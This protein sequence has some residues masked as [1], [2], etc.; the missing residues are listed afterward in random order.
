MPGWEV[1]Q[2]TLMIGEQNFYLAKVENEIGTLVHVLR[3][4]IEQCH[5]ILFTQYDHM[6]IKDSL[7]KGRVVFLPHGIASNDLR[8]KIEIPRGRKA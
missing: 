6:Q 8:V 3:E 4:P 7:Q 5:A 2:I 1:G